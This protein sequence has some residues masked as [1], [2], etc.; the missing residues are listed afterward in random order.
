M[1]FYL[2]VLQALKFC[3]LLI[4]LIRYFAN[5]L[6]LKTHQNES[7]KFFEEISRK[8]EECSLLCWSQM[9]SQNVKI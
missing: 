6:N 4:K 7:E 5:R 2:E 8:S 3:W 9:S 1:V